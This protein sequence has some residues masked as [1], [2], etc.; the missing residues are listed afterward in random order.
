VI[1]DGNRRFRLT[2]LTGPGAGYYQVWD[3]KVLLIYSPE[4]EPKYQRIRESRQRRFPRQHFFYQ[5]GTEKFEPAVSSGEA[6]SARRS[7]SGGRRSATHA[8]RLESSDQMPEMDAR[9]IALDE[10]TGLVMV[11]GGGEVITE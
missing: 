9:E 6:A 11:Y 1:A 2:I 7:C 10:K 5:P 3:G 4:E 8:T